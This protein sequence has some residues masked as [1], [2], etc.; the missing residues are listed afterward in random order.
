MLLQTLTE[1]LWLG[2]FGVRVRFLG[3]TAGLGIRQ[4][5][6]I[7]GG[8]FKTEKEFLKH[9]EAAIVELSE[10]K[11]SH[12]YTAA[13]FTQT[14]DVEAEFNGYFSYDRK[15]EKVSLTAIADLHKKILQ[16]ENMFANLINYILDYT[17][18]TMKM[19]AKSV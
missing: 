5:K 4:Q 18:K 10:L 11:E 14:T 19:R 15:V 13:V 7:Q 16:T 1:P 6:K 2:S 17:C 3:D 12:G 8:G 9:Y